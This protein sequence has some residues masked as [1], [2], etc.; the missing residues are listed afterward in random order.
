MVDS[1]A[2]KKI[3]GTPYV[4][5]NTSIVCYEGEY[6]TFSIGFILP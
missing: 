1:V 3:N 4:V 6:N 5:K 2:C